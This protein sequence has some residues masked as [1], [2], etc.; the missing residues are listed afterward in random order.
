MESLSKCKVASV[1]QWGL[2]KF[3]SHSHILEAIVEV[4]IRYFDAQ[5]LKDIL[6]LRIEVEAH[7]EEPVELVR[8]SY[9]L[10]HQLLGSLA[11]MDQIS[12]KL[13]VLLADFW[14]EISEDLLS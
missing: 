3:F 9:F 12:D 1:R 11:L 14:L 4:T 5:F 13:L 2:N 7:M 10:S 6:L 8:G